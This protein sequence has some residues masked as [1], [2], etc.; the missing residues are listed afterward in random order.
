[1]SK[2]L[3]RKSSGYRY[4]DAFI[5]ANIIELATEHFCTRFLNL[6]N[7]PCG[8]TFAQMTQAARSG[9]RNFAEGCERLMT[10]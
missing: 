4:M 1:M 7:D 2:P 3:F 8:K 5:L 6:Q 10:S 9:S